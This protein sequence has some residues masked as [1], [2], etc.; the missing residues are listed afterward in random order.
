MSSPIGIIGAGAVAKAVGRQL[1]LAG[2]PVV[3]LASRSL[4][5]AERAAAFIDASVQTVRVAAI[6]RLT[7][8]VIVAVVDEGI[9]PAA[10]ALAA[11]EMTGIV[12]HTSGASGLAPLESLREAGAACCTPCNPLSLWNRTDVCSTEWHLRSPVIAKRFDWAETIV[13]RLQDEV[14]HLSPDAFP[15]YHAGAVMASNA[16][17]SVIDA[18]L[19]LMRQAGVDRGLCDE[20]PPFA[21]QDAQL[22]DAIVTAAQ[23]YVAD[24]RTGRFQGAQP[25]ARTLVK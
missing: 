24:V 19:V 2:E 15:S 1:Q 17:T 9:A 18:A 3:A 25:V 22:G 5:S 14:I 23:A 13:E 20:A 12:P 16:V 10:Q 11:A 8:R 21:K 4:A 7:N 6:P